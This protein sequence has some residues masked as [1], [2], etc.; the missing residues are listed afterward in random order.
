VR[1]RHALVFVAAAVA[2][3]ACALIV[4]GL[5]GTRDFDGGA[6][7]DAT[8]SRTDAIAHLDA[9][10]H[11]A[12]GG[13]DSSHPRPDG[14]TDAGPRDD[15]GGACAP[16]T[17]QPVLVVGSQP[18]IPL[19]VVVPADETLYWIGDHGQIF[20]KFQGGPVSGLPSG[21]GVLNF[22]VDDD[23]V[24]WVSNSQELIA[25]GPRDGGGSPTTLATVDYGTGMA[26]DATYLYWIDTTHTGNFVYRYPKTADAAAPDGG[27]TTLYTN[28]GGLTSLAIDSQN[29]YI[30][31]YSE[32]ISLLRSA[33]TAPVNL[34]T[35][36]LNASF[37]LAGD[38][39]GVTWYTAHSVD[40]AGVLTRYSPSNAAQTS[41]AASPGIVQAASDGV[42]VYW[43]EDPAAGT[44]DAS[45]GAAVATLRRAAID[46]GAAVVLVAR[47][48][49]PTA[50]AVGQDA[51]FWAAEQTGG[52]SYAISSVPK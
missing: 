33:P 48:L 10:H 13:A 50:I 51:V 23:N 21:E 36:T 22:V 39:S 5:D 18:K 45:A 34:P 26:V 43:I 27:S 47:L 3:S 19:L 31:G 32:M 35:P 30:L 20:F 24:Y 40:D 29:L 25:R 2:L 12:D 17:C 8:Y 6:P 7:S 41:I 37:R 38:P 49:H 52:A 28:G 15:G 44:A 1:A 9:S 4:G 14:G 16:G 46:G 42:H 11:S